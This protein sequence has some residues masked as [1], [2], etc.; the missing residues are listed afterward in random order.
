MIIQQRQGMDAARLQRPMAH[1]VRLPQ[2]VRGGMFEADAVARRRRGGEL[3]VAAQNGRHRA[4]G[5]DVRHPVGAEPVVQLAATP[6]R[7]LGAQCQHP[8]LH[9]RRRPRRRGVGPA[10]AVLPVR[11]AG[12]RPLQPFGAG[13]ATDAELPAHL[14]DGGALLRG[15]SNE[16]PTFV[17]ARALLPR[18]AAALLA[19]RSMPHQV[20][21][22]SPYRCYP[23]P[24][25]GHEGGISVLRFRTRPETSPLVPR[26]DT[27]WLRS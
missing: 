2:L 7:M 19:G 11:L 21:P 9:H 13:L 6:G 22:M 8:L 4:R 10:R 26:G 17:H 18:H 3:V 27:G 14:R 20:L 5:G 15:E 25:S 23:C 24:R 12:G 1:E 16:F